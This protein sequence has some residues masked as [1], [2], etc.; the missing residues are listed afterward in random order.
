MSVIKFPYLQRKRT[1]TL[2]IILTLAS[3]LFSVTAYSFLGF[4]NGFTS[5]VG[6]QKDIIALYSKSSS[7][8]YTGVIPLSVADMV[9]PQTGVIAISPR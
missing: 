8:P 5:Y 3:T 6:E 4:Y 7:T 2:I 1:L 9:E